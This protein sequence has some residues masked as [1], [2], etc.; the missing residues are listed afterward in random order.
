M[1]APETE[2][3]EGGRAR[4]EAAMWFARLRADPEEQ[5]IAAFEAWRTQDPA[6]GDAYERLA[7]QWD[8]SKFLANT[9][10]GKA[11]N[12]DGARAWHRVPS[13]RYAALAATLAVAVCGGVFVSQPTII[14]S[15]SISYASRADE[16]RRLS[17]EDGS[18]ITLDRDSALRVSFSAGERRVDMVRGRARFEIAEDAARKFLV[19]ADDAVIVARE[20]VFDVRLQPDRVRVVLL[21]GSVEVCGGSLAKVGGGRGR[22][23]AA[24]QALTIPHGREPLQSTPADPAELRWFNGIMSFSST[25]LREVVAG[26]NRRNTVKLALGSG[27]IGDLR[28]TGG[29]AADDPAG[30]ADAAAALFKLEVSRGSNG[31]LV[32]QSPTEIKS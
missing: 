25:P 12:L 16:L 14:P 11:R 31:V 6:N 24:G 2:G 19:A 20:T 1:T 10:V 30:F 27:R 26:F 7:R 17:L 5:E 15:S 21:R 29:F 23:L 4:R 18:R 28:V 13:I 3:G 8:Q 9:E 32:L 22:V